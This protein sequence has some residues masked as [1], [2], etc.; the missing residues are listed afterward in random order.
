LSP[1]KV[2]DIGRG[3]D[4]L[5]RGIDPGS[6]EQGLSKVG[7]VQRREGSRVVCFGQVVERCYPPVDTLGSRRWSEGSEKEKQEYP[8]ESQWGI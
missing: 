7:I 2:A 4:S 8:L 5:G 3:W 6:L 1:E